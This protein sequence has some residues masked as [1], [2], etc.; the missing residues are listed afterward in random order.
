MVD[1]KSKARV[2]CLL[3]GDFRPDDLTGLFL[4]AR[5]H[6][7]GRETITDIGDFVAHHDERDRGIITR[8]T[9]EW[10]AVARY[11][12]S[13]LGPNGLRSF[14]SQKMPTVTQ[15]YF[16]IAVNRIE[17]KTIRQR[18]GLRRAEAYEIMLKLADRLTR[19]SDGTWALPNN[20]TKDEVKLI[21]CVSSV[22]V[23]KGAFEAD[24]LC[25]DFIATLKSNFT[26]GT[27]AS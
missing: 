12:T 23:V 7:N 26:T 13:T 27:T 24:R 15:D 1:A 4:F 25:D 20:L 10:F 18:T 16:K 22:M 17:A 14:D 3:H 11:H 6:C 19:N 9:R 5:D 2:G 8:S 21:E